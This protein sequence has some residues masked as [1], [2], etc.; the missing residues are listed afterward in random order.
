MPG[1]N[2]GRQERREGSGGCADAGET[3]GDSEDGREGW[4]ERAEVKPDYPQP[5]FREDIRAWYAGSK[6]ADLSSEKQ[7]TALRVLLAVKYPDEDTTNL[8]ADCILHVR[9]Y[10]RSQPPVAPLG[11][12]QKADGPLI[13]P[14]T[15]SVAVA[16]HDLVER[17]MSVPTLLGMVKFVAEIEGRTGRNPAP[18][19]PQG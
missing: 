2:E 5:D 15:E 8:R 19:H 17:G 9:Q 14:M 4:R 18:E 10:V 12:L 1:C 13:F 6:G 3:Q 16:L 11:L 7:R